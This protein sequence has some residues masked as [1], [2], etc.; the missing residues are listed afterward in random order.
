MLLL[1]HPRVLLYSQ[2]CRSIITESV[3]QAL[4]IVVFLANSLVIVLVQL[5]VLQHAVN[6]ATTC[7]SNSTHC[8]H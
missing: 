5:L 7:K 6:R 4:N 2:D 1:K 3:Q 8:C